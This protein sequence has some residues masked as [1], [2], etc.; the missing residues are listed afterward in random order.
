MAKSIRS[1]PKAEQGKVITRRL[2]G[3]TGGLGYL[4]A[5]DAVA[6]GK[7]KAQAEAEAAE[8][9]APAEVAENA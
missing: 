2:N 1:Y 7:A 3:N 4:A 9:P 8:A 6:K 5:Q